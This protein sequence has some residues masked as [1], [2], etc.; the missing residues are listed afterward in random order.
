MPNDKDKSPIFAHIGVGD[1][2][3]SFAKELATARLHVE[4]AI[5]I[6][7]F[8]SDIN[9]P[10][11][12]SDDGKRLLNAFKNLKGD[13]YAGPLSDAEVRAHNKMFYG[14]E[15]GIITKGEVH[16]KLAIGSNF[17]KSNIRFTRQFDKPN[18]ANDATENFVDGY[19]YFKW[20]KYPTDFD[21]NPLY[22]RYDTDRLKPVY[23]FQY[24]LLSSI[25][26]KYK[27]C[28][29]VLKE[30]RL[31]NCIESGNDAYKSDWE[32]DVQWYGERMPPCFC[33]EARQSF[34]S[35]AGEY[36]GDINITLPVFPNARTIRTIQEMADDKKCTLVN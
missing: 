17:P 19:A 27:V 7:P 36:N 13:S 24:G 30:I 11:H 12:T 23:K 18:A 15:E 22:P 28:D 3:I 29:E 1:H 5:K 9:V 35:M 34:A 25:N 16:T 32:Y 21:G 2:G 4:K 31:H 10:S 26:K 33:D 20:P 14:N 6:P 8:M